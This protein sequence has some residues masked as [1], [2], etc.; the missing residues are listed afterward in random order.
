MTARNWLDLLYGALLL[1]GALAPARR[2][3]QS[4]LAGGGL[5]GTA[6]AAH[7]TRLDF[8]AGCA[9]VVAGVMVVT[10]WRRLREGDR[11]DRP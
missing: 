2:P 4:L 1:A 10:S 8:L 3:W 6:L 5:A 11:R 9:G 7:F